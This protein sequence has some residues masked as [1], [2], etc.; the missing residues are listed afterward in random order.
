MSFAQWNKIQ[1]KP[2]YRIS[3]IFCKKTYNAM[4]FAENASKHF[5]VTNKIMKRWYLFDI[6]LLFAG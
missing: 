3:N 6:V 1:R 5:Y 4:L 2:Q